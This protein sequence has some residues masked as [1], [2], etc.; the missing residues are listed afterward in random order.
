MIV[1]CP[2]FFCSLIDSVEKFKGV[3]F[4]AKAIWEESVEICALNLEVLDPDKVDGQVWIELAHELATS[5]TRATKLTLQV[6]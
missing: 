1:N 3:S 4:G 5:S 2:Q 6:S